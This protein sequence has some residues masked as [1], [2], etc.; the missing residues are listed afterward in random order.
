MR[1]TAATAAVVAAAFVT[2][3]A[4]GGMSAP[5]VVSSA[6]N[7]LAYPTGAADVLVSITSGYGGALPDLVVAGDGS[8]FT[9]MSAAGGLAIAPTPGP[10]PQSVAVRHLTPEGLDLVLR[11]ADE[12]RL[13]S[14]PPEY[15]DVGVTDMANT[16]VTLRDDS[17]TYEHT[18]YALGFDDPEQDPA[19]RRLDEFVDSLQELEQLAGD[20]NVDDAELFVPHRWQVAKD[21]S[22]TTEPQRWPFDIAPALGCADLS[23]VVPEKVPGVYAAVID[24]ERTE[25]SVVAAFPWTD[26]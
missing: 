4:E 16:T 19:R 23:G 25:V 3:C 21:T 12:L 6:P 20:D 5:T 24:G 17:G 11:Q 22:Y 2:G 1:W 26:C 18:A 14:T 15:A 8:V 13:L 7:T 10:P 9:P